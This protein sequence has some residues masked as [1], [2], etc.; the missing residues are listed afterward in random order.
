MIDLQ[1]EL[2]K[3]AMIFDKKTLAERIT[4]LSEEQGELAEAIV[5]NNFPEILEESV[6]NLLVSLSVYLDLDGEIDVAQKAVSDGFKKGFKPVNNF[7]YNFALLSIAIG[8]MAESCQKYSIISTSTYKG[9]S[10]K[11]EV[12]SS[13]MKVVVQ[14]A[15]IIGMCTT[16]YDTVNETICIK[17][18]K[19]KKHA[20]AGYLSAAGNKIIPFANDK[21]FVQSFRRYVRDNKNLSAHFID[22]TVIE[23]RLYDPAIIEEILL[24]E[25]S[26]KNTIVILENVPSFMA[27]SL[28]KVQTSFKLICI[29]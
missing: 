18:S 27:D 25:D 19:W 5:N 28:V 22:F 20:I 21:Q 11:E 29:T 4:K 3:H 2:V 6:D 1:K 15:F 17:N 14:S 13:V 12:L 26:D 8:Q 23:D 7:L 24:L 10:T 16:D 9:K